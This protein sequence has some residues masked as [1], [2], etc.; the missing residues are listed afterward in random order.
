MGANMGPVPDAGVLRALQERNLLFELMTHPDQ[1]QVAAAELAGFGDLTVVVEHTGWPRS[2]S[3]EERALWQDR[4]RRAGRPRRQRRV[5][6]LGPGHA[7]S[8]P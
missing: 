8:G 6:A 4:H 3:D 2:N 1:L 7:A 5:Q